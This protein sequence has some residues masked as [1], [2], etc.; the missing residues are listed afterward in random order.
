[1]SKGDFIPAF[2][3]EMGWPVELPVLPDSS[4]H[5]ARIAS[6]AT[7]RG[8][9]LPGNELACTTVSAGKVTRSR[10]IIPEFERAAVEA[11]RG[12]RRY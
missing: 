2:D 10:L 3:H 1:M 8:Q 7:T 4:Y 5:L 6:V 11:G 12:L 9:S